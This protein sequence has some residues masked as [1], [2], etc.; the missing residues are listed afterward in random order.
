M[1]RCGMI[2]ARGRPLLYKSILKVLG[3]LVLLARR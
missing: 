3:W 2:A 1:P